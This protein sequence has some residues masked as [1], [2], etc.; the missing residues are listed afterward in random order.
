MDSQCKIPWELKKHLHLFRC[1]L[2][3]AGAG[4]SGRKS[5][6]VGGHEGVFWEAGGKTGFAGAF[7][8]RWV[9]GVGGRRDRIVALGRG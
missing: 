8:D 9:M 5:M 1:Q 6:W 2:I 4:R 3:V 7:R